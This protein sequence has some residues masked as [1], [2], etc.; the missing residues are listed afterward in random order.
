[1]SVDLN[2]TAQGDGKPVVLLHPIGLDGSCWND[3]AK[4]LSSKRKLIQVD[5]RGHGLSP[6][7][8]RTTS[9][10][11]HA[12]DVANLMTKLGISPC[13]VVGVSFGGMVATK[14]AINHSELVSTIVVSACPSAI[15][16]K[17]RDALRARGD[18]AAQN[19]MAAIVPSTL[20][21]W[22]TVDFRNSSKVAP[23][24]KRLLDDDPL[25]WRD[26]WH[27]I[28]AMDFS[29]QLGDISLPVYCIHAEKDLGASYEALAATANGVQNGWL[30]VIHDAPHMVHIERPDEFSAL[31]RQH[32]EHHP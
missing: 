24:R 18:D 6:V 20:E 3:V 2:W 28:A 31:V 1:M 15:P 23:F 26:S 4:R 25:T 17:A 11:D 13:P 16:D 7:C 14:L 30:D 32:L 12:D 22:F 21:R 19:G 29:A 27:A 10:A 8:P 9:L 5:L